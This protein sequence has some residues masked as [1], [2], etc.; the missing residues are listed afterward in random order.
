MGGQAN[1]L[2]TTTLLNHLAAIFSDGSVCLV[3][4]LLYLP[5]SRTRDI[6]LFANMMKLK[7]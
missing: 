1:R 5:V 2:S 6:I 4:L 3:L 7:N